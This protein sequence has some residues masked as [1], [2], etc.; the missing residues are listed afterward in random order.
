MFFIFDVIII[1]GFFDSL[2]QL[3][4]RAMLTLKTNEKKKS[5]QTESE[6]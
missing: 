3:A 4:G 5:P 6:K 1:Q 2:C